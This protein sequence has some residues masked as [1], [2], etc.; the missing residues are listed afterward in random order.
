M[1]ERVDEPRP[2]AAG[3]FQMPGTLSL[4][5]TL[6]PGE[7][8]AHQ[9]PIP[10]DYDFVL[11]AITVRSDG[12]LLLEIGY[13]PPRSTP[14]PPPANSDAF[15]TALQTEYPAHLAGLVGESLAEWTTTN[16]TLRQRANAGDDDAFFALLERDPRLIG[17]EGTVGKVVSWRTELECYARYQRLK[18]SALFPIPWLDA[19]RARMEVAQ[20]NLRRLGEVHIAFYDQRGKNLLPPPGV[21]KGLYYAFLCLFAGLKQ[22]FRMRAHQA[23]SERASH[24]VLAIVKALKDVIPSR[25][26]SVA[27]LAW[28]TRL[29]DELQIGHAPG[30]TPDT[31][32]NVIGPSSSKP[33]EAA[34]RLTAQTF[35]VSER[36]VER[37]KE[38]DE[39]IPWTSPDGKFFAIGGRP[40]FELSSF[41]EVQRILT[42]PT[43]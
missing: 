38:T 7:T 25:N 16:A 24:A 4:D 20:R 10:P 19:A 18:S 28:A 42:A 32:L 9:I 29:L 39:I 5:V 8:Q 41:P 43:P 40:N 31:M 6:G 21:V 30:L 17:S 12:P 23:G 15:A 33:S 36:T 26:P 14:A 13:V 11:H 27:Y 37:V 3:S 35:E 22:E 1:D 2:P 34:L